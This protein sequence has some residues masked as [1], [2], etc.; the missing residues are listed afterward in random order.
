MA[1]LKSDTL[2]LLQN[3]MLAPTPKEVKAASEDRE[4]VRRILD[5]D[6]ESIELLLIEKCGRTIEYLARRYSCGDLL[7]QLYLLLSEQDWRRLRSWSGDGS[8]AGWVRSVAVRICLGE[9]KGNRRL[10]SLTEGV[11]PKDERQTPARLHRSIDVGLMMDSIGCLKSGMERAV[12]ILCELE[13]WNAADAAKLL[14]ITV[15]NVYTINF[16]A[17]ANLRK[18][19]GI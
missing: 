15:A 13:G 1:I 19:M 18:A 17:K 5:G 9:V 12:L 2:A 7:A 14:G 6:E 4:I 16:R 3:P 11:E 8:L 10:D